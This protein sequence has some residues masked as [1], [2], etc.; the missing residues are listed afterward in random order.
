[1]TPAKSSALLWSLGQ[2]A[3][4]VD[5]TSVDMRRLRQAMGI[6]N[7][8]NPGFMESLPFT[9]D[10]TLGCE[11]E[12]QTAVYGNREN[13]DLPRQ[14][15]DSNYFANLIERVTCEDTSRRDVS[16]LEDFL[17]SN[18]D[19]IWENS[20]VRI[21]QRYLNAVASKVLADDLRRESGNPHSGP[22]SDYARF[23]VRNTGGDQYLRIPTSYL[24]KLVLAQ[25]V[26]DGT[27]SLVG[28][29]A[30]RLMT[31]YTNDNC[32]PEVLSF[33]VQPYQAQKS[34]GG[35]VADETGKR[36]L[37]SHL[38]LQYAGS[39]LGL[40]LTGQKPIVYMAP[41]TPIR[42]TELA[43]HVSDAY[44]REL[45]INPCLSGYHLG[46][47]K[48]RYMAHCHEVL[49]RSSLHAVKALQDAGVITRNLI[50]LPKNST[51]SLSNNGMHVSIG[52]RRI[53]QAVL[54]PENSFG[55]IQEK[56]VGDLSI[57]I[58]EHFLPLF[59]GTYSGAP[60]RLDF[61]DMHP[62]S[63][64]RYLPHQLAHRHLRMFWRAWKKKS[65]IRFMQKPLTPMGPHWLDRLMAT[66][67]QLRGDFV[68][69]MRLLDYLVALP[70]TDRSPAL[71]GSLQS[72][73]RL[74][75][76]LA[77][78]GVFDASM[79]LYLPYKLRRADVAG[80]SGY[81]N[82]IHSQ[83][84]DPEDM[85]EA[86]ELQV[87]LTAL[88]NK[89][90]FAEQVTRADIPDNR[91]VE[92][93]RRQFFFAVAAGI[94]SIYVK[95]NSGNRFLE[96]VLQYTKRTRSSNRYRGYRKVYLSDYREALLTLIEHEAADLV[97]MLGLRG[98]VT[99]LR[100]RLQQP[101]RYS[102]SGKLTRNILDSCNA[103]SP[104]DLSAAE[105]NAG[106]ERY[107]RDTLRWQFLS[108]AMERV[109]ADAV[110]IEQ[111][112]AYDN[113]FRSA[114]RAITGERSVSAYVRK[115]SADVLEEKLSSAEL[116]RFINILI[117]TI[118]NDSDIAEDIIYGSNG[119]SNAT[120]VRRA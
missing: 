1:M 88:A 38:L 118:R 31:S 47:E 51:A 17:A 24:F 115:V 3:P 85:T 120:S 39:A 63:V 68:P 64:L 75:Q 15:E 25:L 49:S 107:Y 90:V 66:L 30:R 12:L 21:P 65:R 7:P 98:T 99:N 81:E 93:E 91:L 57:K 34:A 6:P 84:A 19:H 94:H 72:E 113:G 78:M 97:D 74:K 44:Y 18:P 36:L 14:I 73:A 109:Q 62:E 61:S 11:N 4:V 27:P 43:N 87:L 96:R 119:S 117:L 86:V 89:L 5:G 83:F 92:S 100:Q 56:H 111:R 69:D 13:V 16:G 105:F 41:H 40:E 2:A 71:D 102:A 76:D 52:S 116:A 50:V 114:L 103:R 55:K 9:N 101:K 37:L 10:I 60:H 54:D 46:E 95:K 70:S 59:V 80:F 48:A 108:R 53:S 28:D 110:A 77:D 22:R 32:S 23:F 42:Q 82:R 104:F 35:A 79:S 29:T 8:S 106:A 45:Y 26:G 67:L 112:A 20:W 58:V 33:Y